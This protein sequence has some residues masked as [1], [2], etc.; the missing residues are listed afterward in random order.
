MS[1][2]SVSGTQIGSLFLS[3]QPG[4]SGVAYSETVDFGTNVA[5]VR[6][7]RFTSTGSQQIGMAVESM[8]IVCV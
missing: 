4:T 6:E 3:R 5:N 8:N 1:L 2:H 7:V